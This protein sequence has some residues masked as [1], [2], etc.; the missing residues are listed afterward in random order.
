M[1]DIELSGTLSLGQL[2]VAELNATMLSCLCKGA[3]SET[4]AA[5]RYLQICLMETMD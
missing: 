3:T 1:L 4:S 5:L 2:M